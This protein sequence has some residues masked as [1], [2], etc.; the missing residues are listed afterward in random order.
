MK[1]E[2]IILF[3]FSILLISCGILYINYVDREIENKYDNNID[4]GYMDHYV[5][6]HIYPEKEGI[7]VAAWAT[8]D[9]PPTSGYTDNNS[10]IVF[11][12]ISTAEYNILIDQNK[13]SYYIYPAEDY[14][15]IICEGVK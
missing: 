4:F 9:F 8:D 12:M 11:P 5:K 7:S 1:D 15:N 3:I 14:Y 13:C 2:Y 6:F 10:E